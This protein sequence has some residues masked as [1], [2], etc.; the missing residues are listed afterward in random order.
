MHPSVSFALI[1][2]NEEAKLP[3][4]LQSIAG[5]AD[6]IIVVDTG[7]TDRTKEVAAGFGAKVFDAS[8]IDDFAAA[9][10]ECIRHATGE[11]IFWLDADERIDEENRLKLRRLFESLPKFTTDS[12]GNTEKK[13]IHELTRIDTK[14]TPYQSPLT[15]TGET[16]VPLTTHH[17]LLT[18]HQNLAYVMKCLC[19]DPSGQP[20]SRHGTVVDHVRLFRNRPEH[21]WKYRVHEQI[22]PALKTT[23]TEI[24]WTDI[25]IH[26][27]GYQDP[28]LTRHKLERNVRLLH[29]DHAEHPDDPYILFNLG[30]A[31]QELGKVPESLSFLHRSLQLSH[32][33]DSIVKKIYALLIQAHWRLGQRNDALAAC[34]AG[35][36]RCPADPELLYLEGQLLKDVGQADAAITAFRRLVS[37]NETNHG[38]HGEHGEDSYPRI[39]TNR[40]EESA[41]P[42]TTHNSPLT[43]SFGSIEV[44]FTG[45]LARN[46]LA[47]LYYGKG[48]Q[49]EAEAEWRQAV[50]ER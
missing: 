42:L 37:K 11:W 50:D 7:S 10:N 43:P 2:R 32:P 45:Y 21:R 16:P 40:H 27:V 3:A 31:Y 41:L 6:E 25:V 28:A 26:H 1:L 18:T 9:R 29:L 19:V 47:H 35:R 5:I 39:N 34:R 44:G 48:M 17:S 30:W 38:E 20:N 15:A 46:Q 14:Q 8:W 24:R 36:A 33:A 23:G 49:T 22:L 13:I 4:C 12:T